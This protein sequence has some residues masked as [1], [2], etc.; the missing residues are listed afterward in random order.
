MGAKKTGPSE[1]CYLGVD[2]G[3]T[4][5]KY[6]IVT[7]SGALLYEE[8]EPTCTGSGQEILQQIAVVCN[9]LKQQYDVTAMGIGVPCG[10]RPVTGHVDRCTNLPLDGCDIITDLEAQVGL[11]VRAENDANCAALCEYRLG[12]GRGAKHMVLLTIGTGIGGGVIWNGRLY[13]G[14]TGEGAELGH[15]ITHAG[16]HSC[17]CGES[18]C[19]EQYASTTAL[20]RDT[21]EAAKKHPDSILAQCV[22]REF[23]GR[24]VFSAMEKGCPVAAQVFENFLQELRIGIRSYMRIFDPDVVVLGGGIVAQGE[25]LLRPLQEKCGEIPIKLAQ[26]RNTA[27][28]IGAALLWV[29][30]E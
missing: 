14:S 28:M 4:A 9:R 2:V 7:Q 13:H 26:L 10:V 6:G 29:Q 8:S 20:L 5:V 23:N 12:A 22:A 30:P 27:G 18:G 15:M 11:P 3:G 21:A 17:P 1:R 24:T 25:T 16:G 19:F